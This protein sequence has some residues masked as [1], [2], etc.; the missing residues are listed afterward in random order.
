[1]PPA[2]PSRAGGAEMS[3]GGQCRA[4]CA[5]S[6]GPR[7]QRRS[8]RRAR[9]CWKTRRTQVRHPP[10]GARVRRAH[11]A[12]LVAARVAR[13]RAV[14]CASA[15]TSPEGRAPCCPGERGRR[16]LDA[17]RP[18]SPCE[19]HYVYLSLLERD[20][21]GHSDELPILRRLEIGSLHTRVIRWAVAQTWHE[22]AR[23]VLH[24]VELRHEALAGQLFARALQRLDEYLT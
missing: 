14:Q 24:L 21:A 15:R 5:W 11:R 3:A 18:R 23:E 4:R 6:R 13:R 2:G 7:A 10:R 16:Q 17:S 20:I 9:R 22:R 19:W 1:M 12:S 8:S